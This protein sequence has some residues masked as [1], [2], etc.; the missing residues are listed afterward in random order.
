MSF[1][2]RRIKKDLQG[3]IKL[4][5]NG[6]GVVEVLDYLNEKIHIEKNNLNGAFHNDIVLVR[7][8]ED[9]NNFEIKGSVFNIIERDKNIFTGLVFKNTFLYN[10]IRS[11]SDETIVTLAPIFNIFST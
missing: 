3:K 6:H 4:L 7:L 11:L 2:K 5:S 8:I 10:C 1:K 9:P